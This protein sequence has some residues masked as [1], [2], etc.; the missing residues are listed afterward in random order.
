MQKLLT[1]EE[2]AKLLGVKPRYVHHLVRQGELGR[3]Q[4]S[5]RKRRFT[6]EQV[7]QYIR[8]RSTPTPT[9]VDRKTPESLSCP[10][11]GGDLKKSSG[12]SVKAQLREEMRSWR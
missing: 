8:N 10:L 6:Q 5:H 4:S 11:K 3:V 9:P 1:V 12:D 7:D 2:V